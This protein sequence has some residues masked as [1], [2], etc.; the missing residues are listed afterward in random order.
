[1]RISV[2]IPTLDEAASIARTLSLVRQAGECETVVVDGGSTD[3]TPTVA[4]RQ[5]DIVLNSLRG[6]AR[7]MN[8]GARAATGDVLLFLHADSLLPCQFNQQIQTAFTN[9][10]VV[11]GRF[12]VRL[13]AVGWQFRMIETLMNTRS[14]LSRIFTGDQAIFVRRDVFQRLG[15]FPELE[16][17]EDIE[18]SRKLKR[19]GRVVCLRERVTT[20]A[21]RWQRNGVF[22]T[23]GL[24]WTLRLAYFLGVPPH[25]LK[26]FY[27]D[28]R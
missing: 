12:D 19:A 18:F 25:Q 21:R 2:V 6:R 22:R 23:I 14:R 17:M 15:G 10:A 8:A 26:T 20:S 5:A 13:D 7:Q 24:M 3:D 1:M 16:L 11:G 9:A 27:A 4:R 28:T